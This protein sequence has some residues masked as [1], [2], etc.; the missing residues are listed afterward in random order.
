MHEK[1][2][3]AEITAD[4]FSRGL[5]RMFLNPIPSLVEPDLGTVQPPR[6]LWEP[7]RRCCCGVSG[8]VPRGWASL[9]ATA[10]WR[11]WSVLERLGWV[12]R[13]C[14]VGWPVEAAGWRAAEESKGVR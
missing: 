2:T 9:P 12:I 1:Q 10:E 11:K 14:W 3:E 4:P 7:V 6:A 13:N 8:L 5:L